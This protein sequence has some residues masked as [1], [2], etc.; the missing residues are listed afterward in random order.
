MNAIASFPPPSPEAKLKTAGRNEM[1][2]PLPAFSPGARESMDTNSEARYQKGHDSSSMSA[3]GAA[4]RPADPATGATFFSPDGTNRILST[5]TS[6]EVPFLPSLPSQGRMVKS[7]WIITALPFVS[8][9]FAVLALVPK[10]VQSYQSVTLRSSFPWLT[11]TENFTPSVAPLRPL[12]LNV[13]G[14]FPRLPINVICANAIIVSSFCAG[15]R[16]LLRLPASSPDWP[17][18]VDRDLVRR[19]DSGGGTEVPLQRSRRPPGGC[20]G[21]AVPRGPRH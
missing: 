17:A 8:Q 2:S 19:S 15:W 21:T 4:L 14:S 18:T 10:Q 3:D 1:M 9:S 20:A 12:K 5:F 13:S 11:A 16:A 7:P 6:S